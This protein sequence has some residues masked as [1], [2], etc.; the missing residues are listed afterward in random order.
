MWDYENFGLACAALHVNS[1]NPVS[2][3]KSLGPGGEP[4]NEYT[5]GMLLRRPVVAML[6]FEYIGKEVERRARKKEETSVF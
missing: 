4:C 3:D 5:R 2:A 6:P 1:P